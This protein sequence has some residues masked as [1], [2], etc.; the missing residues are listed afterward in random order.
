MFENQLGLREN[1]FV[2]GHQAKYVY[3]SKEHQE[4]L[5]HLRYGIENREP[6]VLITGEVGTGKTTAIYDALAEWGSLALVA[7]ITNSA[8]T[9]SEL[10]EEICLRF[11]VGVAAGATKPQAIVQLERYLQ[12]V[13]GRGEMAILLL[14]EAQNLDDGLLEEIRLLSNQE[15]AGEKLLQIFLV[16]Q[17]ELEMKLSRQELRQLRQRIAIHY[18]LH[19]LSDVETER[20]IHHR[21]S[22]AGG[23]ASEL[24]PTDTCRV[25]HKLTHGIPREINTVAGQALLNAFVDDSRSVRPAHVKAMAAETE[26][27]SVL[28]GG[29]PAPSPQAPSVARVA[30]PP[31]PPAPSAPP[32]T[33]RAAPAPTPRIVPRPAAPPAAQPP[34]PSAP[35]WTPE[36]EPVDEGDAYESF[37]PGPAME[38]PASEP[39]RAS[40][41]LAPTPP[42]VQEPEPEYDEPDDFSEALDPELEELAAG[43]PEEDESF[44]SEF[45]EE[46]L[47]ET[48]PTEA[49]TPRR[50]PQSQPPPPARAP[51]PHFP[52]GRHAAEEAP[53]P[54][55]V[56]PEA[57]GGFALPSWLDD[58]AEKK[59][60]APAAASAP[61]PA[62]APVTPPPARTPV[63]PP[64]A[65]PR[66]TPPTAAPRTTPAPQTATPRATPPTRP[67]E[68][69]PPARIVPHPGRS[70]AAPVDDR[71]PNFVGPGLSP[72]LREK[73]SDEERSARSLGWIGWIIGL[74]LLAAVAFGA[75]R[76][77]PWAKKPTTARASVP[78]IEATSE[79]SSATNPQTTE[80]TPIETAP[81]R[82][83]PVASKPVA[84]K[85]PVSKP[86]TTP[87]STTT[88]SATAKP[89]APRSHVAAT[90]T[91]TP[92]PSAEPA[93][94]TFGIIVG[95]FLNQDRAN[96]ESAALA[97]KSSLPS[98]VQ[99]VTE[100][101]TGVFRVV[102]GRFGDRTKAEEAA[103]DLVGR[104]VINEARVTTL[105]PR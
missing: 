94:Q 7:L 24:F 32:P 4:A 5:A 31:S 81:I 67:A 56:L 1:P 16:G 97:T 36:P 47:E 77:G 21:V 53:P 38:P 10:I 101:G 71:T 63:A 15:V 74:I 73:L 9:R 87:K 84:S 69:R 20:Y 82:P 6:F 8:L 62:P 34:A 25:I 29:A 79:P 19:P 70:Q 54:D 12:A 18:R 105:G 55:F 93:P 39:Q 80:P 64:T 60:V 75:M 95:T 104:G 91:P 100:D 17:P 46:S 40:S 22:V 65:A 26:F 35:R 49:P 48:L 23:N 92:A 59:K 51:S 52:G 14:D 43:P 11:G 44:E 76:F 42:P 96:E 102:L 13:R 28:G 45:D 68:R 33:A 99:S 85:P 3:P 98:R 83:A 86:A 90:T 41:P 30:P 89:A 78:P 103:S 27:H 50:E 37:T 72:R 66:A 57:E 61:P 58:L 2:S 88:K